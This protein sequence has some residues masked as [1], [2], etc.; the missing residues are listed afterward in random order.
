MITGN[1]RRAFPALK[2]RFRSLLAGRFRRLRR[3]GSHWPG[4]LS[5]ARFRVLFPFCALL[6]VL[7]G[8]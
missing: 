8:A 1:N 6:L 3:A 2:C 4:S 7:F 5:L